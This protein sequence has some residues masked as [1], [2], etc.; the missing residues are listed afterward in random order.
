MEKLVTLEIRPER[1]DERGAVEELTREAFWDLYVPGASEHY[2]LHVLRQSRAFVPEL[3]CVAVKDGRVVGH[4]AYSR[5]AVG[6]ESGTAH[7][8][9]TFG[10]LSVL[11]AL[12]GRGIGSALISHTQKLA[13]G[14]GFR[15]T[16]I[17]GHPEYYGRFGFVCGKEYGIGAGD[18]RFL[19]ALLAREH[20]A[21][22]LRGLSGTFHE[23]AAFNV[24]PAEVEAFDARFP[25]REKTVRESQKEFALLASAVA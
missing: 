1:E 6:D 11:P 17:Y 16:V 9:V 22:A 21:G 20:Y 7:E 14:M 19:K 8:M 23:D 3:N 10:P 2:V 15:A 24:D 13:A 5:S 4:I 18:G 25:F 12:Q